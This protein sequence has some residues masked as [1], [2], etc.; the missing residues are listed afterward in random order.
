MLEMFHKGI[1]YNTFY[2]CL[3]CISFD[4]KKK[5]EKSKLKLFAVAQDQKHWVKSLGHSVFFS[6]SDTSISIS[7]EKY[8]TSFPRKKF[9]LY[10]ITHTHIYIYFYKSIFLARCVIVS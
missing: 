9:S 7:S 10:G 3:H 8:I 2:V 1:L 4:Q 5:R 6:S